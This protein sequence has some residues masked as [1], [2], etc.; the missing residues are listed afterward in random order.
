ML[1]RSVAACLLAAWFLVPRTATA[2]SWGDVLRTYAVLG[3]PVSEEEHGN[4]EEILVSCDRDKVIA[5][6]PKLQ[7][8]GLMNPDLTSSPA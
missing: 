8:L 7:Q 5:E 6:F 2:A 1:R 4:V 3:C